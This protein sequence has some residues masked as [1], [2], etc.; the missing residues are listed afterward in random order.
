[1]WRSPSARAAGGQ[2]R[3]G[4]WDMVAQAAWYGLFTTDMR[5]EVVAL[6]A[7]GVEITREPEDMP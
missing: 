4:F 5:G 3:E 7:K 2:S 1:M 6:R